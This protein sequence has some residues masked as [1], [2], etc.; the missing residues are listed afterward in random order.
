MTDER[1]AIRIVA[2]D[3]RERDAVG[4]FCL[5]VAALYNAA[6]F[7][8]V[9]YAQNGEFGEHLH[10][11]SQFWDDVTPQDIVFVSFSIGD[12]ALERLASLGNR[13]ILYFHGLTPPGFFSGNDAFTEEQLLLGLGQRPLARRFDVVLAN[14]EVSAAQLIDGWTAADANVPITICPPIIG[15]R[16]H[17][18]AAEPAALPERSKL[19][20][21]VGRVSPHK[22]I[23]TLL[24][25][26]EAMR[27][28]DPR[29]HLALVG[30][31]PGDYLD[32]VT[33]YAQE[34]IPGGVTFLSNVTDGVIK[35]LYEVSDAFLTFTGHE[36]YCVPVADAILLDRPIFCRPDP[37]IAGLLDG[38]GVLLPD[39]LSPRE[40]ARTIIDCLDDPAAMQSL[41]ERRAERRRKLQDELC[42]EIF[43]AMMRRL[44]ASG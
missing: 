26:L 3:I 35:Y 17:H 13:K 25:T 2:R 27:E 21:Y 23:M 36:G 44:E 4:N 39:E 28:I 19:L 32:E 9:L 8:V 40:R 38:S 12:P 1:I 10:Q 15:E 37:A 11:I 34:N 42:S 24:E 43:L 18:I 30:G 41:S 6:G 7:E 29:I 20:L 31:G 33:R 22:G 5:Q 14:S 16:W